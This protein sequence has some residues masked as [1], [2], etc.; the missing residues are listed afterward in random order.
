MTRLA[1]A[2]IA[3]AQKKTAAEIEHL[4]A[5]V[6]LED[7]MDYNEPRDWLYP[8]REPLGAASLQAGKIT[9]AESIFREDL[10]RNPNNARSLFGL[11]ECLKARGRTADFE[12][13]RRQFEKAWKKAD[14]NLTL[15][16]M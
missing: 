11:A 15:A 7:S 14:M 9:E 4:R 13:A 8:M 2:H 10:N 3:R 12:S 5:A 6:A 16:D 1:E